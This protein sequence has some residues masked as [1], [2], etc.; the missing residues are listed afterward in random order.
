MKRY[1][2]AVNEKM[3]SGEG[4]NGKTRYKTYHLGVTAETVGGIEYVNSKYI[5]ARSLKPFSAFIHRGK[6][7]IYNIAQGTEFLRNLSPVIVTLFLDTAKNMDSVEIYIPINVNGKNFEISYRFG[8]NV[9]WVR[10]KEC[11]WSYAERRNLVE[12]I[13]S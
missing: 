5:R 4:N 12:R 7:R 10:R 9:I 13:S 8:F 1:A 11:G 2:G 3:S 6:K